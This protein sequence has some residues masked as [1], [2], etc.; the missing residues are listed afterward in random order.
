[1][2]SLLLL[3]KGFSFFVSIINLMFIKVASLNFSGI[4]VSPFEYHD[5]SQ[6]KTLINTCFK[7][8]LDSSQLQSLEEGANIAKMDLLFQK[9]RFTV[10]YKSNVGVL[11]GKLVS[12]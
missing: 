10:L 2:L 12:K 5:G 11:R 7:R 1:M 8:L 3:Y 6:E 4:N 9:N